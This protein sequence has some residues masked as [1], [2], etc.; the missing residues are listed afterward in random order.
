VVDHE[1]SE[2][3]W[4]Y[5]KGARIVSCELRHETGA[6]LGWEVRL[7]EAGE[8][9]FAKRCAREDDA[10]FYAECFRQDHLRTGFTE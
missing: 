5:R 7:L 6:S 9:R 2:E 4:R 8:V 1:L 3:I 10:R